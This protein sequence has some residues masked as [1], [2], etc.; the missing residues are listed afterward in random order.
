LALVAA[1]IPA[2]IT[3]TA[4]RA[5]AA[6]NSVVFED[7]NPDFSDL[8]NAGNPDP[9][10]PS[11][12]D[13]DGSAGGRVNGL[14]S[15]PGSNQVFYAASEWGGL[16]KTTNGGASWSRLNRHLPVATWDVEVDP[17]NANRVY[18]TSFYD[19]RVNSLAGINVSTDAG[20]T[21][22]HPA[23]AAPPATFNCAEAVRRQE[24]SAFGIGIRPDAP[25]NVF[26]GTNCGLARSTDSGA[27]WTFV[28]P[29]SS[30][31]NVWDVVVQG[32][33]PTGQGIVDVCGDGGHFRST[34]GGTTWT[35]GTGL[36]G[37]RCS[38]AVS[39][40]EANVLF[41]AASNNRIWESDDGGATWNNLGTPEPTPQGRI[42]FV[43]VND[44]AGAAFD[45][46]F[47]DVQLWRG[48]CTTP[49][50][51][52]TT[53]RRCPTPPGGWA[54]PFTRAAGA[55]DDAGDIVFDRTVGVD[56]CPEMFSSDGGLYRN[57]DNSG[58][59]H[60]PNWEQANTGVHD[61]WLFAM[62]GAHQAGDAAE[63]LYF[64]LQ[65]SGSW[66]TTNA[67][68]ATPA[69]S[70]KDCCDIF[71]IVAD[72][73]RVVY[74]VCCFG[75]A[76]ATRLFIRNAGMTGGAPPLPPGC[77]LTL[78]TCT[79][80]GGEVR[81]YPPGTLLGFRPHD[82]IAQF[83][84]GS[85]AV[86]TTAGVF[87]T[88]NITASPTVWT[89][90]GTNAPAGACAISAS[91]PTVA[92][93]TPVFYVQ[94]GICNER[95]MANN[96]DQLWRYDGTTTT[97]TWTRLDTNMAAGG[98]GIFAV[99]P[100]NPNR[101]YA[102]NIRT[103]A[104]GGPQMVFSTD[105]GATWQN[106]PELDNLMTGGGVFK[107]RTEKGPS[108]FTQFLGYPQ[109][110]LLAYDAENPNLIVA[111][112]RD[113]GVFF[114]SDSGD[115][116]VL[117]TDPFNS[118]A[119]GVPHLPRP[120]FAYFDHEP[121]GDTRLYIGTQ[122]RGV[123]RIS[124]PTA[125]LSITKTDSPDPV[126]NGGTLT[127]TLTV[128]NNGPNTAPGVIVTDTLP[129]SVVYLSAS[130]SQGSCSQAGGTVTCSLGSLAA[131]A[132][133][134]VTIQVRPTAPGTITNRASV[135]AAVFDPTPADNSDSE[136]TTVLPVADLSISKSDAPDPVLVGE[137]LV[138]GLTVRND[139]PDAATGVMVTDTLPANVT[140][141]SATPSQGS[142]TQ[143]GG[144]VT[145]ALGSVATGATATV[146]IRVTPQAKGTITNTATVTSAVFDPDLTDNQATAT[147][148]VLIVTGGAF[149]E[150]VQL[151]TLLGTISSGPTPA[152]TL[153]PGGGGPFTAA[154]ARTGLLFLFGADVLD[155]RTQGGRVG[156]D[157]VV[158][159]SADVAK[160]TILGGTIRAEGIHSDCRADLSGAQGTTRLARLVIAGQTITV[161]PA[162]NTTLNIPG[163]GQVIL[164]EQTQPDPHTITV[165]AVHLKPNGGLISTD[166]ILAQ[167]RC[168]I[169]P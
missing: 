95:T 129:P 82:A 143:A 63:D 72:S 59:C 108:N 88:T 135:K 103:V 26:V 162:P 15:S 24:P 141:V 91:V 133:A 12:A 130:P 165:N 34:D 131:S 46:W 99:D 84:A 73:T 142:C 21:W 11:G 158:T 159:S 90:L 146:E 118:G 111:G 168:G 152:V 55:H 40:D 112:G 136:D 37:G 150:Q 92:P 83:G 93:N 153:P 154:L 41:V 76:P 60:N 33:G 36:P 7:I 120:W 65:D 64:G 1:G 102:S 155:V 32:G 161:A 35:T 16:Y 56:A 68:A 137:T 128:Q 31:A 45:L 166:I 71:D 39:P 20:A 89:A 62:D 48:G 67:G 8:D 17:T 160:A 29:S 78:G 74:T 66:A 13:P 134:T 105:G 9:R 58:D 169:D 119:S 18:A 51:P 139:G 144:T 148:E 107:Y 124:L 81:T 69:W 138:Y 80:L 100:N 164:N 42:P 167:S 116:W 38:I 156:S 123:W 126:L 25:Q 127:Y 113:S 101:L 23:S 49:A 151:T 149:G 28:D 115:N 27:T 61:T 57:T 98:V 85:Y 14:A 44:R 140:F 110:T 106:D 54:G 6:S 2:A 77:S 145:C 50:M 163:V 53:T 86:V 87:V 114:S 94:A 52:N 3:I 10:N 19:G 147:T 121:A 5:T 104:Q 96:A 132:T 109:P 125:D 22:T 97:G 43:A 79:T 157:I 117:L 70:N 122:G 30:A 75:A 47:G 4:P